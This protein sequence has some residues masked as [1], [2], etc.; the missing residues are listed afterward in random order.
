MIDN[1]NIRCTE[2]TSQ[3]GQNQIGVRWSK[4][5]NCY[6]D[7]KYQKSHTSAW[8]NPANRGLFFQFFLPCPVFSAS[9]PECR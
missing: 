5:T 4:Q 2:S 9:G 7:E 8:F 3:E 6:L 1:I